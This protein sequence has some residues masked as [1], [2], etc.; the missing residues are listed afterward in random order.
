[1]EIK[2]NRFFRRWF[3]HAITVIFCISGLMII[4]DPTQPT[5]YDFFSISWF[6]ISS[7]ILVA[8]WRKWNFK[9]IFQDDEEVDL[10]D[11]WTVCRLT[12]ECDE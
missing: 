4:T 6:S 9:E 12:K 1:M 2:E 7:V 11:N 3:I 5:I 8:Y 10:P